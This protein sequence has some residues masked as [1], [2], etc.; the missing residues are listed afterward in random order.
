MAQE[1]INL[2]DA[3][4]GTRDILSEASDGFRQLELSSAQARKMAKAAVDRHRG[5]AEEARAALLAFSP[6]RARMR[7][8]SSGMFAGRTVL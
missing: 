2:R 6:C 3:A 5:T 4:D 7:R 8:I 1:I